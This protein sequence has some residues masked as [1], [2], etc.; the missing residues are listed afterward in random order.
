MVKWTNILTATPKT[1]VRYDDI[2][3]SG[4]SYPSGSRVEHDVDACVLN[5]Y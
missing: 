4:G 5:S 3:T 2:D 1:T